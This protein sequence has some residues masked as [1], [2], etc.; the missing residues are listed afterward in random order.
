MQ[1]IININID[2]IYLKNRPPKMIPKMAPKIG[3]KTS[4]KSV[5]TFSGPGGPSVSGARDPKNPH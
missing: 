2:L 1:K 4:R 5:S 3:S